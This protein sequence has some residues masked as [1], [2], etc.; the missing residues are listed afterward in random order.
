MSYC[1][2]HAGLG[3]VGRTNFISHI[4]KVDFKS[5]RKGGVQAVLY[6]CGAAVSTVWFAQGSY[7]LKARSEQHMQGGLEQHPFFLCYGKKHIT[8]A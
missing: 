7:L 1:V 2:T 4:Q 6:S 3:L 5:P 8:Q